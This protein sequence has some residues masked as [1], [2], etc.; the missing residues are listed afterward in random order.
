MGGNLGISGTTTVTSLV[1]NG[2]QVNSGNLNTV[3]TT[4]VSALVVSGGLNVTGTSTVTTLVVS[5]NETISG[6]LNTTGTTNVTALVVSG[7]E[8]ILGSLTV[9][10]TIVGN[11][12]L[13]SASLFIGNSAGYA[14][15]QS[16]SGD[17]TINNTG[18][19]SLAPIGVTGTYSNVTISVDTKGRI[20]S[21][22]S[23]LLEVPGGPTGALQYNNAGVFGGSGLLLYSTSNPLNTIAST[24]IVSSGN[25]SIYIGG[26]GD[27]YSNVPSIYTG[28][29]I[30][31]MKGLLIG[32]SS[33][34]VGP[35]SINST[36]Q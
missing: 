15:I 17:A 23:G 3:G 7:N 5:G 34:F 16:L 10:G 1:V 9:V 36:I 13:P 31:V 8:T 32:G 12:I 18:V 14:T 28:G 6:N 20:T 27:S 33:S 29:G 30:N 2:N 21:A 24:T 4:T 26:T 19:L 22:S 11:Q 25:S 35:V